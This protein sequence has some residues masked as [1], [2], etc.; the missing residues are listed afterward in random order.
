MSLSCDDLSQQRGQQDPG[1]VIPDSLAALIAALSQ[2]EGTSSRGV[3]LRLVLP[4]SYSVEGFAAATSISRS[5]IYEAI[6]SGG[7]IARHPPNSRRTVITLFD[8]LN[9]LATLPRV[10]LSKKSDGAQSAADARPT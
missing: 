9:W 2:V 3:V 4:L 8:G 10:E 6:A 7:L 5:G 1:S